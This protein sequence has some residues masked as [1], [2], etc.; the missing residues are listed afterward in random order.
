MLLYSVSALE[1]TLWIVKKYNAFTDFKSILDS[2]S[3]NLVLNIWK[4][5]KRRKSHFEQYE[6]FPVEECQH[7]GFVDC[8]SRFV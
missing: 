7:K 1:E 5:S 8:W 2:I 4:N 3:L 6:E